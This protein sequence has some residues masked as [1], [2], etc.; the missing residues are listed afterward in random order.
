[1][2]LKTLTDEELEQHRISVLTEI[3]R[4][5]DLVMIP[6]QVQGLVEKYTAGGG[7]VQVLVDCVT[8]PRH[9]AE[10]REETELDH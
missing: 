4:R 5:D 2:D 9:V 8:D 1:M 7:D 3:A 6:Q 10:A